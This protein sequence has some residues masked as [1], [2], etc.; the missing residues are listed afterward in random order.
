[1][2]IV[3][4]SQS[5]R[6]R[7]LL[8]SA[9]V[10]FEAVAPE[11]EEIDI[12]DKPEDTVRFNSE[13]KASWVARDYPD[14]VIIGA[15]TVVFLERIMGKPET[16]SHAREMLIRLSGRTHL[17]YTAVT[18]IFPNGDGMATRVVTSSVTMK[19]LN[20]EM[21]SEYLQLVN[22]LDKAGGYAI[23]EHGE[24]LIDKCDG[25]YS[26]VIGLPMEML[27]EMLEK[28]PETRGCLEMIK[29]EDTDNKEY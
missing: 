1:M 28:Y 27:G 10:P 5:Q 4:A 13:A 15:D 9:G 18:V 24:M 8:A 14:S 6:R 17:V 12:P 16:M 29:K 3:L 21:I 26:N 19:K 11:V 22:P 7:E 2:K 20:G 23:Q 25:S